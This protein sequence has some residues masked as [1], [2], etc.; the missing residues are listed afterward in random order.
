[1][2]LCS[3]PCKLTDVIDDFVSNLGTAKSGRKRATP[4][5]G[6]VNLRHQNGISSSMS[7]EGADGSG[8]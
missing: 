6:D 5:L 1:M 2:C 3:P 8:D 7:R 4:F